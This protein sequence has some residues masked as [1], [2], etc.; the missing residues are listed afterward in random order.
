MLVVFVCYF[1]VLHIV[2]RLISNLMREYML[3]DFDYDNRESWK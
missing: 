1:V 2:R 3:G